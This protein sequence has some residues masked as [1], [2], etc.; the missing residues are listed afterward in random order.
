M[1][2]HPFIFGFVALLV[3]MP[4]V[5]A[6]IAAGPIVNPGNRHAYY[7]LDEDPWVE[8]EKIAVGLGGHLA[9]IDDEAE[10]AWVFA[11]FGAYG[12]KDRS[13]WIGLREVDFEGNY[14]WVGGAAVTYTHWLAGQPDNA[15]AGESHVHMINAG[16]EYGHPGGFWND[17]K[18]PNTL[19][20]TFD[21]ICGVVEVAP[22]GPVIKLHLNPDQ[23]CWNVVSGRT[24]R[25]QFN[26][27]LV[28]TG[29]SDLGGIVTG[30]GMSCVGI[31][32]GSVG[33]EGYY[34]VVEL[35]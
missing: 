28:A 21:P 7:L 33:G 34:R 30:S 14:Q 4:A 1:K 19:F 9:T 10:Q 20:P 25:L 13:L 11:T 12:G 26:P 3:A 22:V 29:W 16:N 35:P 27:S 32:L 15:L 6:G 2:L 24:Y 17:I 23:V 8:S 18:S 5:D 31:G